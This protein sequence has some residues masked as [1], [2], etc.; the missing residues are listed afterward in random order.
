MA[1]SKEPPVR[2]NMRAAL[3]RYRGES[4]FIRCFTFGRHLLA[5]LEQI[6]AHVPVSGRVLDLG[7]GHGLFSNLIALGSTTRTVLGVDPSEAKIAVA[8]R[9]SQGVPNVDYRS[10]TVDDVEDGNFDV[11]T[12]LDV[13]YLLPD[14]KKLE[15]LKACRSRLAS[16]GLLILKTNDTRPRWKYAVVRAE[17]ELMVRVIGFT[18]GGEVHFRGVPDYLRLLGMAGFDAS[19]VSLDGWRPMPHRLFVAHPV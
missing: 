11:I 19:V 7:C 14:E 6:A 3:A 13:L 15:V 12:I 1:Y 4:P 10:C 9:S 17:E 16:N 5:P 2:I 18:Y 8:R